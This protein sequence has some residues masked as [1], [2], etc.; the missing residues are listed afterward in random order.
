MKRAEERPR[1]VAKNFYLLVLIGIF[2]AH[3]LFIELLFPPLATSCLRNRDINETEAWAIKLSVEDFGALLPGVAAFSVVNDF[4]SRLW[5]HLTNEIESV[6]P[7][8][9]VYPQA[10]PPREGTLNIFHLT[11]AHPAGRDLSKINLNNLDSEITFGARTHHTRQLFRESAIR[12]GENWSGFK[13]ECSSVLPKWS[14]T[15]LLIP[16]RLQLLI[17]S[18]AALLSISMVPPGGGDNMADRAAL[19][20]V[21][22]SRFHAYNSKASPLLYW[23]I[24]DL[25]WKSELPSNRSQ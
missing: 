2:F 24:L 4:S 19:D 21:R 9:A 3:L 20:I 12:L 17:D 14:S 5:I 8:K 18:N 15:R 1:L 11:Y 22:Q 16:T 6:I 13:F 10:I 7:S 23:G 25:V